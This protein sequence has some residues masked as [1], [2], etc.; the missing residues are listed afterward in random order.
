[1]T[2]EPSKIAL[3]EDEHLLRSLLGDWLEQQDQLSVIG[4]YQSVAEFRQDLITE[5]R[6]A[7]VLIVDLLLPDGDGLTAALE[8]MSHV[9]REIPIVVISGN[10]TAS[11]FD[12]L[13]KSINGGWA[14]LL[15]DSNGLTSLRR[16]IDAVQEGLVMV[17]PN[18]KT[19]F[20]H[21]GLNASLTPQ[22]S[23]IM[24]LVSDGLSNSS[25]AAQVFT[26]EKTVERV[27]SNVYLKYGI[28]RSSKDE[29]PRVRATLIFRGLAG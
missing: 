18:L 9:G 16:A 15:K 13:S 24:E 5:N 12:R 28:T 6:H 11:L 10:P 1:M 22:E 20:A 23:Q 17:D 25:V 4:K 26:S 8:V 14:C 27:L 7:D 19:L 29:N 3:L 2:N 21:S